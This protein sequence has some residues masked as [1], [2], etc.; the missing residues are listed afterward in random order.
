M[1]D[2][3]L[4]CLIF[5]V[6][7]IFASNSKEKLFHTFDLNFSQNWYNIQMR[8]KYET[9]LAGCVTI[10]HPPHLCI[11]LSD[12]Q[13]QTLFHCY[14]LFPPTLSCHM[15]HSFLSHDLLQ[16]VM[17]YGGPFFW[18]QTSWNQVLLQEYVN[19]LQDQSI[20]KSYRNENAE[21]TRGNVDHYQ[22]VVISVQTCMLLQFNIENKKT[23]FKPPWN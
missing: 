1:A 17:W 7:S 15:I 8:W 21:I 23:S 6:Y 18:L 4:F 9:H 12:T 2:G 3:I 22:I 19:S 16:V 20:I 10:P 14:V 11:F 5:H 13:H